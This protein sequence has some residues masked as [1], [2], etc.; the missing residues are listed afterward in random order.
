[1]CVSGALLCRIF[2]PYSRATVGGH[3]QQGQRSRRDAFRNFRGRDPKIDGY[4]RAKGFPKNS[5][6]KGKA[7]AS[8][9]EQRLGRRWLQPQPTGGS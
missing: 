2:R 9:K 4:L 1:M 3:Q 6:A 5:K 8:S 7:K